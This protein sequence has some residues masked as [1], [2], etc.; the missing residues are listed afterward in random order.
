MMLLILLM[1][2]LGQY[3]RK[4]EVRFDEDNSTPSDY[5]VVVQN[6][7]PDALEPDDWRDFFNQFS[8]T[9]KGVTLCTVALNNEELLAKLIFWRRDIKKLWRQFP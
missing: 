7:P 6:P 3:L 5:T 4:K 2:L 1:G 9:N 8:D